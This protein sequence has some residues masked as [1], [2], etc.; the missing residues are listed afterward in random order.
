MLKV[1]IPKRELFD[2]ANEKF[3]YFDGCELQLEHSLISLAKWE[4]RWH[5]P[6]LDKLDKSNLEVIDYIRCMSL[7]KNVDPKVYNYIPQ[8][9][10]QEIFDYI[11]DPMTATQFGGNGSLEPG[12]SRKK[13]VITAEVVYYWM[14]TLGIPMQCEK[15]HLNRLLTLIR[16]IN[17]KSSKPTPMSKKDLLSRNRKLNQARRHKHG[18]RG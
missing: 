4:S 13:E 6:F 12:A 15:W 16:V 9:V 17:I 3:I 10:L 11:A 18:S 14:I 2:E 8:D 7:T 1:T 5:K